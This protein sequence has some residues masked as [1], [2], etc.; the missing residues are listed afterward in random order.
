MIRTPLERMDKIRLLIVTQSD[1]FYLPLFFERFFKRLEE[2]KEQLELSGL[3]IQQSLGSKTLWHLAKRVVV[4]YG[5]W[6]TVKKFFEL[7]V[8]KL[9]DLGFRAGMP[10]EPNAIGLL[11][12]RY[13]CPLLDFV[14]VNDK[15]FVAYVKEQK[16][17]LI[18][19]VS[20][21]QIFGQE[22]LAAPPLG[23]INLHNGDLPRYKGMLPNFWQ[24]YNG[25]A[26]SILTIHTMVPR[27]DQG[28]VVLQESTP[29]SKGMSLEKLIKNTKINSANTLVEW[30][31]GL[32]KNQRF[33]TT[34]MG[35]AVM[36]Y[37]SFP[38]WRDV[39]EFEGRGNRVL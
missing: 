39:K 24:M 12:K 19:S 20:A 28:R 18:V 31:A 30:L 26:N 11:A 21:S 10:L 22:I 9:I 23:C 14:D 4:L 15:R 32:K 3:I 37:Y 36:H 17:D 16:I 7:M 1:P 29:I 38:T 8:L 13:G 34:E 35:G 2:Y 33:E 6:G 5:F 27:L 25:E